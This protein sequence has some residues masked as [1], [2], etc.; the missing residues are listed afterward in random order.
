M[1]V[2]TAVLK[3][4]ISKAEIKIPD[5][6]GLVTS[7]VLNTK[8]EE[9]ENKI[10]AVIGF[11]KET[12]YNH[13]ISDIDKKYFNTSDYNNFTIEILDENISSILIF[14]IS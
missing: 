4:K 8:M 6:S 5:V 13:K 9:V 11:V 14:S 12:D 7:A 2:T 1:L 3:N 10:P